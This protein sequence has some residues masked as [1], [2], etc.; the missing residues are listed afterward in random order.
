MSSR[1]THIWL[2]GHVRN[3]GDSVLRR[4]YADAIR[5]FSR[6]RIW[7]SAPGSGYERGL[8]TSPDELAPS[9]ANWYWG[10]VRDVLRGRGSFAF[11]AGEFGVTKSYFAGV[12]ALMPWLLV[13]RVTG[14]R[15]IWMGAGVPRRRK[16]FI[17]L[18]D[19]LAAIS[20]P[21]SWR[22]VDSP[23]LMGRGGT[24]P[25]WAFAVPSLGQS[26]PPSQPASSDRTTLTIA[27]RGDRPYPSADWLSAVSTLSTRLGLT[28]VTVAQTADDEAYA[29][30][31]A[32]DLGGSTAHWA[33]E[34]HA[35][36]EREVRRA[37]AESVLTFSD[38][39]HGL[40][41]A[42]TEGSVPLGWAEHATRK[43]SAHFEL[44]G[45]DWV[46][47]DG[48]T[49]VLER[50]NTLSAERVASMAVDTAHIVSQARARIREA[51]DELSAAS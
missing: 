10:Y 36:Q 8:T 22:D 6:P 46:G 37:Y 51:V 15:I 29:C 16:R 47:V 25:D 27:L 7:S 14:G 30:R 11:N 5:E 20:R 49:D 45:A 12:T 35:L 24:M 17:W 1:T 13:S 38:R 40:I 21:L 43:I 39:L 50:I 28:I 23:G 4:A 3:V 32:D 33:H 19:M 42:A 48:A 34:S 44:V 2:S 31:L 18:F 9:F 41:M 26:R